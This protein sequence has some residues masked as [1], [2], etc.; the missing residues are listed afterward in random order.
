MSNQCNKIEKMEEVIQ[1]ESFVEGNESQE[2]VENH[3]HSC[4]EGAISLDI[5]NGM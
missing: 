1:R 3:G 4:Y 5:D 2:T